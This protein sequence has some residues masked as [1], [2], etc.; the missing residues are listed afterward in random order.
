MQIPLKRNLRPINPVNDLGRIEVGLILNNL[1]LQ[2]VMIVAAA[3]ASIGRKA[4]RM[5]H[6][7]SQP[8]PW[9]RGMEDREANNRSGVAG[10]EVVISQPIVQLL[11]VCESVLRIRSFGWKFRHDMEVCFA[12]FDDEGAADAYGTVIPVFVL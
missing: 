5:L 12:R 3:I 9:I 11:R 1:T 6:S 2:V 8:L 10:I 7:Q 4:M